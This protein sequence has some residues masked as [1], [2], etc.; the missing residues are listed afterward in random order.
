MSRYQHEYPE[1][2]LVAP[3]YRPLLLEGPQ[4]YMSYWH[5]AAI[6]MFELVVLPLH[7]YVKGSTGVHP[8]WARSHFYSSV[9]H[10]WFI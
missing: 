3:P 5:R 4:G 2:S 10:I 7:V 8:L 6:C 1:P 9:Q